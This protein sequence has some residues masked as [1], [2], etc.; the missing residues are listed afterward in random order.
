M[1]FRSV[2]FRECAAEVARYLVTIEGL[3]AQDPLRVRLLTHLQYYSSHA[4]TRS[5]HPPASNFPPPP[6]VPAWGQIAAQYPAAAPT[7]SSLMTS[8]Q[9]ICK[10]EHHRNAA[11][12]FAPDGAG[13]FSQSA[14]DRMMTSLG[15]RLP[16]LR[17]QGSTSSGMM[18]NMA[19]GEG[20][21]QAQ[22]MLAGLNSHF[23]SGGNQGGMMT[24]I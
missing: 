14:E 13:A 16:S 1:D 23:M 20:T 21:S 18:A 3:D 5:T 7:M 17:F 9:S 19:S 6:S 4:A 12:A 10:T 24:N 15:Y 8:Q 2:G 22:P 11:S